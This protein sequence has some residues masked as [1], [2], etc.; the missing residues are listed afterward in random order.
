M[1]WRV[2]VAD[3][4]LSIHTAGADR[5]LAGK[6]I[7]GNYHEAALN[8]T[9]NAVGTPVYTSPTNP[10]PTTMDVGTLLQRIEMLELQLGRQIQGAGAQAPDMLGRTRV[11]MDAFNTAIVFPEVTKVRNLGTFSIDAGAAMQ[12]QINLPALMLRDRI[13]IT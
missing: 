8:E 11:S 9:L 10:L 12:A 3:N 13:V 7:A 5:T 2:T 1:R 6:D 4:D